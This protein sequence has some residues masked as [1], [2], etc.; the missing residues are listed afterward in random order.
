MLLAVK[1]DAASPFHLGGCV[2]KRKLLGT[3]VV[4]LM[5]NVLLTCC[6]I[7]CTGFF[8]RANDQG[9]AYSRSLEFAI[10]MKSALAVFPRNL[11]FKGVTPK[12]ENGIEWK[13][14]YG[15]I[16]MN[17][18]G[19]PY[20]IDGFNE[21]G[22]LIGCFYFPGSFYLPE[23][24]TAKAAA[25][26][27]NMQVG[28]WALSNFATVK[29]VRENLTNINIVPTVLQG[30]GICPPLHYLIL[31]ATGDCI[32]IEPTKEGIQVHDN[33]VNVITNSPSFDWHLNNLR[34]YMKLNNRN[35]PPLQLGNS[36]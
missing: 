21:K 32:V 25:S 16:G 15:F 10:N 3:C 24:D 1:N 29:E 9:I 17:V 28:V 11:V 5:I 20:I 12:G 4:V 2:M 18:F 27:S 26:L 30:L 22:L 33:P 8:I 13:A 19:K 7:G 23:Y 14:K 6:A 35:L 34:Q 31:D 36:N